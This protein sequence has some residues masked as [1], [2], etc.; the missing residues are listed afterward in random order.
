MIVLYC[1]AEQLAHDRYPVDD[2]DPAFG[3]GL[4][5]LDQAAQY[6]GFPG[7]DGDDAFNQSVLDSRRIDIRGGGCDCRADFLFDLHGHQA[8]TVDA[9]RDI[10]SDA[11]F[12]ILDLVYRWR[13][14]IQVTDGLPCRYRNLVTDIDGGGLVIQYHQ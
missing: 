13:V 8:A 5:I 1:T 7:I 4:A 2:G 12:A 9:G 10:Q 11:G 14:G 6:N 3:V